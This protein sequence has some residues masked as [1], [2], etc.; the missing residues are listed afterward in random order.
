MHIRRY[1]CVWG[2]FFAALA[3]TAF[4]VPA[5]A[6]AAGAVMNLPGCK[7]NAVP[8]GDD[9]SSGPVPLGFTAEAY[10][11]A[12][13]EIIVNNN[14][15]VTFPP[16]G[17]LTTSTPF[18]LS[19]SPV[20]L[21]A[22]FLADVDTN[23]APGDGTSQV[24]YGQTEVEGHPAFCV[25]WVDVGYGSGHSDKTNSFQLVGIDLGPNVI[26]LYNYDRIEWESGDASGGSGGLG[27]TTAAVGLTAG[28]GD[29]NH[30]LTL[31]GSFESGAFLDGGPRALTEHSGGDYPPG[32]EVQEGRYVFPILNPT[33]S[34][35]TVEG[36]V[37]GPGEEPVAY[38]PVDV[39]LTTGWPC[40]TRVSGADGRYRVVNLPAGEYKVVAHAPS[41][42]YTS[43]SA[44]PITV[45]GTNEYSEDVTLGPPPAPPPAGTKIS[46]EGSRGTYE[47]VPTIYW[48]GA[49]Q[50]STDGCPNGTAEYTVTVAGT[51][52]HTGE[53]AESSPGHYKGEVPSLY[54]S[55]GEA[56]IHIAVS[57]C[58]VS[59]E[60]SVVDFG[61]YIDPSGLVEDDVTGQPLAGA[62]VTLYR[63]PSEAGLFLQVPD[64]S[65]VM[66][67]DNRANPDTTDEDGQFGW[68]VTAGYYKVRASKEG[69]TSASEPGVVDYEETEALEIPPPAT[70][71]RLTLH[72]PVTVTGVSPSKGA[73]TGGNT[74]TISGYN[75]AGV[76]EVKF[77]ATP[78]TGVNVLND[79]EVEATVPAG[80]VGT[81]D[82][83]AISPDGTSEASAADEYS[84]LPVPSISGAVTDAVSGDP[85]QYAY[86]CAYD[87][88]GPEWETV[89]CDSTDS[90][91][92]YTLSGM[93]AGSYKVGFSGP[94]E[95]SYISQ[96]YNG[97]ASF[98]EA[99]AIA[100]GANE[101]KAGID[102]ELEK[103]GEITGTVTDA[104]DTGVEFVSVCAYEAGGEGWE[105][106]ACGYTNSSGK[107]TIGGLT[108]GAYK[109]R[110]S[111]PYGGNYLDQYYN[112]KASFVEAG[113][114]AVSAGETKAGIDA[115][116]QK[117]GE[118]TGKVTDAGTGDPIEGI[119]VCPYKVGASGG[120]SSC[121]STDSEGE[122]TLAGLTGGTYT[123]RFEA[124]YYGS[125]N[126]LTQFYGGK[127]SQGEADTFTL[128]LEETKG[129]VDAAMEPGGQISGKVTDAGHTAIE[130]AQV[131]IYKASGGEYGGEYVGCTS[132][133]SEGEYTVSR[134]VTGSYKV[135]FSAPYGGNYVRQYYNGE[136]A[137]VTANRVPVVA[138]ETKTGIDAEMAEGGEITGKVTDAGT[139]AP[140]EYAEV[141]AYRA[142]GGVFEGC[143]STD[144][145]G[146]YTIGGLPTGSYK[147]RFSPPYGG[148]YLSQYYNGKASF[149]EADAIAVSAG[150]ARTG[151]DAEL[152]EGGEIDGEVT[153]AET[154]EPIKYVDVCVRNAG[155]GEYMGCAYTNSSGEYAKAGLPTGSYIVSFEPLEG[156]YLTQYYDEKSSYGSADPASVTAGAA[157]DIDAELQPGA[158]I[159]GNVTD[160]VTSE[161]IMG[162]SVC[163]R[164]A[165]GESTRCVSTNSA[166]DYTVSGLPTGEYLVWFSSGYGGLNYIGEYYNDV[167]ASSEA[168]PVH[169]EPGA[170]AEG[171][172]AALT[173]GG[174]ISG[175]VT[176]AVGGEP[177]DGVYVCASQAG[178]GEEGGSCTETE[179][180]GE[181]TISGLVTGMYK[182]HFYASYA[183]N[184]LSQ[185]YHDVTSSGEAEQV[186]VTEGSNREGIDAAL[187]A[188]GQV[189]GTVTDASSSEPIGG[190]NVCASNADNGEF[191]GCASTEE[192][193]EYTIPGLP[194]GSYKVTFSSGYE[195]GPEGCG[196]QNY[197]RQYY[198]DK[199][200]FGE[201]EA[202]SVTAGSTH[203]GVDAALEAGGRIGG[204]VTR[205]ANEEP[206]VGSRVCAR[207]AALEEGICGE[208][209]AAGVYTIQG[210]ASGSYRVQFQAPYESNLASQYY[211]DKSSFSEADPVSV[212]AGATHENVN[213]ELAAG[214]KISGRVT[215]AA[216]EEPVLGSW[217]CAYRSGEEEPESCGESDENGNYVVAG[218]SAG[219]HKIEFGPGFIC[220]SEV[221]TENNYAIQFYDEKTSLATADD[222]SVTAGGNHE[223]VD[224]ALVEPS[225]NPPV[226]TEAPQLTGTP[227]V[228]ETL[229][230]SNGGWENEPTFEQAWLRDGGQIAGKEGSSYVVQSAD[231][232]HTI[233]C[234]VTAH[235]EDGAASK[236]SNGLYV[237]A[238]PVNTEA[239]QL[240]GTPE[241]GETLSCSNGTWENSPT[242]AY[243]WLRGSTPIAGE[244]D[245]TY[246]VQVADQGGS[247]TCAV[248]ATNGDGH[249]SV[250]SN[251]LAVPAAAGAPVNTV[252]PVLS[253]MPALGETLNCSQGSWDNIPTEYAYAWRRDETLIAGEEHSTYLVQAA[254]AGD[255][256]S[257]EVTAG[258][259]TGHASAPSNALIVPPKPVNVGLPSIAGTSEVGQVLTCMHGTW[260]NSPTGYEY[261]WLRDG[262]PI[263]GA[264]GT[265]Y[266]AQAADAGHELTCRVTA[267]N[268]GGSTG[269]TS[270]PVAVTEPSPEPEPE[271]SPESTPTPS[272][273]PTPTTST[274]EPPAEAGTAKA[275]GVGSVKGGKVLLAVKCAGG[276][277]QGVAKLVVRETEKQVHKRG[278]R[279]RVTKKAKSVVIGTAHFSIASGKAGKLAVGLNGTGKALLRKAGKHGL[280]AQLIGT[281][282]APRTVILKGS[283]AGKRGHK[284][285]H[286][287]RAERR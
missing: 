92:E 183:G 238:P 60:D 173:P 63:A 271:P 231:R 149:G 78:A 38:S 281:G 141:C 39:C 221:C 144:S 263:A 185:Y 8:A 151:I 283:T 90:S 28:D 58:P 194:T 284:R 73:E 13:S 174:Q 119:S 215:D 9:T 106:V 154:G 6:D 155:S 125:L 80:S 3:A 121:G 216:S 176:A 203:G 143:V 62:T 29:P 272:S 170:P 118:I 147:V 102:A 198:N 192:D 56:K 137:Y 243:A 164:V 140:I 169:T 282:I 67:P 191:G 225:G 24:T 17:P 75:L 132:T 227:E 264:T 233:T 278:G 66:S 178:G 126:Y 260:Q 44:G 193:G 237:P 175:E 179:F 222:V 258:N 87:A 168:T 199:S 150:E 34:G 275:G 120:Y 247:I 152:E 153:D 45:E 76:T 32:G 197:V 142:A 100:L 265:T 37:K 59:G 208:T 134:L 48:L 12:Y 22:P 82:V 217:V 223:H 249:A 240:T 234:E 35:A 107:Y 204:T 138:G 148:N 167:S 30:S 2:L 5:Q 65:T 277:C 99:D 274:P 187:H 55:H 1:R 161:P 69:C 110:F 42:A 14:G 286:L 130:S 166:G 205:A 36:V 123:V 235:N 201:A 103:G 255:E 248:T 229:H 70:E 98:G 213:A 101:A 10:G 156:N 31:A 19:T 128:N 280:K 219:N 91:G 72:C 200:S 20:A 104:T 236:G 224:A 122:Y 180:G 261:V 68:D 11:R 242:Y 74:V 259:D 182:V 160:E 64:G 177:L 124:S 171:I 210:L 244:E 230:C 86:V 4:A 269:A 206:V 94:Y 276:P 95:G 239:P 135:Q 57:A 165:G 184:Y 25:D 97:K 23:G 245:P 133:N 214:G 252:A 89:A 111:P 195:C 131:C 112:G 27:G 114:I 188:G 228:G 220:E 251:S 250:S 47:G 93:G 21:D 287:K 52:V 40:T 49:T 226:N 158:E 262:S 209:N 207:Q 162:A 273:S 115:K 50:L 117:G 136:A 108:T 105:T 61:L 146:E 71:L 88:A 51:V 254:D 113:A 285:K 33:P 211:N 163:A 96:F 232:G 196:S 109:V 41:A 190:V 79:H 267:R 43:G 7:E 202:V 218:L 85:I 253:G 18:D 46:G 181:Y 270:V 279:R 257:C 212:T 129:G 81:V 83:T 189:S 16:E 116:L 53:L 256:I 15:N 54:P 241:V 139:E 26:V 127:A 246:V 268:G 172:D 77:G 186:S 145:S 84:Y 159:T 266:Q 157:T